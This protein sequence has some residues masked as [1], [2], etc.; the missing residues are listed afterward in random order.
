MHFKRVIS[1]LPTNLKLFWERTTASRIT[2]IYFV[3]S[4]LNCVLQVIFQAQAFSINA[5]AETFLSGLIT[6]GNLSLP[7]G[8]FVLDSKLHFCDHVPKTFSTESCQIVWD[9]EIGG[10]GNMTS[11]SLSGNRSTESVTSLIPMTTISLAPTTTVVL[12]PTT[13]TTL[14]TT[15]TAHALRDVNTQSHYDKRFFP[16]PQLKV[17]G[18]SRTSSNGQ[19]GV[20]LEVNGED[21]TLDSKCLVNL[22]WPVQTLKNT[23][24]EDVAFLAFQ[25]WVLGMSIVALLNES[26]PH[27]IAAVLTHLSVTAWGGFQ[28]S[29]TKSFHS[30]FKRLTT[31][32]ACHVNLLPSYWSS[33]SFAEIPSLAFNVVALVLSCFLSFR[34]IKLFGWQTFKRVGASRAINRTYKFILTLSTVIQLSLFFVVTAVTIWLDQLYNG[35]IAVMATKSSLYQTMLTLV[36]TLLIPWLLTGWFAARLELKF[37]M[38]VFLVLSAL[39]LVGWGAMF[40]SPTFRWTFVQWGFFGAMASVS[41]LLVLIGLI[42]G[43]MCRLNFGKGLVHYLDAEEPIPEGSFIQ[44]DPEEESF[45]EEEKFDFP[46]TRHPIPTFS[47]SF[48]SNNKVPLPGSMGPRFFNQSAVPFDRPVDTELG[49]NSS[50]DHSIQPSSSPLTRHVSEHSTSSQASSTVSMNAPPV[51]LSRWVIE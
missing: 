8:F 20:R 26:I 3:F 19:T 38:I 36:I 34:L 21:I 18:Y 10:T 42:V 6:T 51:G 48:G 44:N 14:T 7:R 23:K 4:V 35:A 15:P 37:P 28:I 39:Y 50:V 13:T 25:F 17:G 30:D 24:R 9:G 11:A 47:A 16:Q 31:D 41:A 29:D 22:G 43:I 27:I 49:T 32:G 12:T 40:D 5:Q 46:T 2:I 33:R 1:V 45:S